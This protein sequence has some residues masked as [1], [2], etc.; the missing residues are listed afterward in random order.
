M[1]ELCGS[2]VIK[3]LAVCAQVRKVG[4]GVEGSYA[5]WDLFS[6]KKKGRVSIYERRVNSST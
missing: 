2:V 6:A 4:T 5:F 1:P 3:G